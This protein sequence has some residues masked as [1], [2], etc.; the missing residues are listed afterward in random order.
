[1]TKGK[2]EPEHFTMQGTWVACLHCG[3]K[4][5]VIPSQGLACTKKSLKAW[6]LLVEDFYERHGKC[7]CTPE[8]PQVKLERNEHEWERGLFVGTSSATIF[9]VMTGRWPTGGRGDADTP[10]DPGDFI[11]LSCRDIRED[12]DEGSYIHV[13]AGKGKKDR[14]VLVPEEVPNAV[15][16]YLASFK[17]LLGTNEPLFIAQ[18]S[19]AA[20]RGAT[21]MDTRSCGRRLRKLCEEAGVAKKISPHSLRHTFA[22]ACLRHGKNIMAVAKL[23]GHSTVSTTQRYVD[24]LDLMEMREVVPGFLVGGA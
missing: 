4:Q 8:S 24:H 6:Q 11:G 13:R 7:P 18:D 2:Q 3:A 20:R 9:R 15:Q 1:M 23:L 12:G 17:R 5:D 14:L 19:R 22:P 10:S 21:T 16:A